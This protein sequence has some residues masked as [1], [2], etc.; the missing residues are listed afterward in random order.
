MRVGSNKG[1]SPV[2]GRQQGHKP[3]ARR[4][5]GRE[6][7]GEAQATSARPPLDR[8]QTRPSKAGLGAHMRQDMKDVSKDVSRCNL[9]AIS[10]ASTFSSRK[11]IATFGSN[12][13]VP[14]GES[15]V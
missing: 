14:R 5:Q 4:Q 13:S 7:S 9:K 12:G 8:L 10:K 15:K 3:S 11:T 2:H 6:L 1:T